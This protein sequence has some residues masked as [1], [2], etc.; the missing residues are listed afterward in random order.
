MTRL[1]KAGLH[2]CAVA[3]LMA[4]PTRFLFGPGGGF[5]HMIG[6]GP[7]P[8]FYMVWNGEDPAGG[9]QIVRGYDVELDPLRLAV[10]ALV[11]LAALGVVLFFVRVV[12]V[13][14]G[15]DRLGPDKPHSGGFPSAAVG[16]AEQS[17]A[18]NRG[19]S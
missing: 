16:E 14:F 15:P 9:F 2:W 12:R 19:G 6:F 10:L 17:A 18:A 8:F 4:L 1:L 5:H 13:A 7:Y 11:W 3:G